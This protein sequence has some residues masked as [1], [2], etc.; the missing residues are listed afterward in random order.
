MANNV[1]TQEVFFDADGRPVLDALKSVEGFFLNIQKIV[2]GIGIKSKEDAQAWGLQLSQNLS[3]LKQ[4]QS[5]MR[6]IQQNRES[7]QNKK[8]FGQLEA[9]EKES[10]RKRLIEYKVLTAD[11]AREAKEEAS[12]EKALA[13]EVAGYEAELLRAQV[14]QQKA[15]DRAAIAS[16][17]EVAA[18]RREAAQAAVTAK[19]RGITNRD[20]ITAA[21]AASDARL[22]QLRREREAMASND[23]AAART[24]ADRIN[25]E[26]VLGRE[27]DATLAKLNRQTVAE[28]KARDAANRR[29]TGVAYKDQAL[30]A[31][32]AVQKT[33]ANLGAV[34]ARDFYKNEQATA[35]SILR[36]RIA[37][38]RSTLES[39]V[40]AQR[41]L[42]I[43]NRRV[44][45]A[46]KL[47][48]EENKV[49][50]AQERQL[51]AAERLTLQEQ[52]T[53]EQA[54]RR[55]L[56]E[57]RNAEFEARRSPMGRIKTAA[58]NLGLY[59]GVAGV[60]Y[61]AFGAIQGGLSEVIQMED[62]LA[63][64]QAIANATEPQLQKMKSAIY[65][66]G[67]ASR[68]SN[69][70]LAKV[71]QTLAQAGVTAGDMQKV[72]SSVTTLATA[73][74]STPDEAV[75][76]V[77]SALGAFQLQ[78]S[79]AARI[80]DLMTSALNRTKLTVQ[81]TGQAIQYVGATAF[82]QNISLEQLLATV[83]AIAQAGVRS[84]STIGTGFRQFLVD[85]QTPSTKLQAQ[86][87]AV[88]L[89]AAQVNVAVRG[90]PAVLKSL[91]EAGFG[92]AQAYGGLETRAAAFYLVAKNNTDI[93]DQLQMSFAQQGAAAIANERAMN[94]LTAQWQRFK[95]ILSSGFADSLEVPMRFLQDLL[96]RLSDRQLELDAAAEKLSRAD[97]G[98]LEGYQQEY[99]TVSGAVGYSLNTAGRD[100]MQQ[101]ADDIKF[102]LNGFGL[103]Q[104]AGVEGIG[105]QWIAYTQK[106][107]G[108]K[109]AT[110]DFATSV[111]MNSE[112][113]EAQSNKISELD[114]EM[115]RLLTQ[116]DSLKDGSTQ[117][118]VETVNLTSRF[119]GLAKFLTN[120]KDK[121]GDLMQAMQRYRQEAL[122]TQ[123]AYLN[124]Q[125]STFGEQASMAQGRATT[126]ANEALSSGRY[127]N[128]PRL[129]QA[130]KQPRLLGNASYI[131]D[132]GETRNDPVLRELSKN[133]GTLAM[134][135]AEQNI[136]RQQRDSVRTQATTGGQS[137]EQRTLASESALTKFTSLS[138]DEQ[139][140]QAPALRAQVQA[141]ASETAAR[142]ANPKTA[143]AAR[144]TL[145]TWE[146]RANAVLKGVDAA[147]AP[148][149]GEIK[150]AAA[151]ERERKAS[152]RTASRNETLVT[153]ADIDKFG[154]DLGLTLG[155]G[156]RTKAEQNSLH[157]RGVTRA[158]GDTSSHSNGGVARDF[159]VRGLDDGAA[160]RMA[161]TLRAQYRAA[162][163]EARVKYERGGPNDGTGRHIHVDVRKGAKRRSDRSEELQDNNE[164]DIAR[165]QSS[166][167]EEDVKIK[168]KDVAQASQDTFDAATKAARA[169]LD[170]L[171]GGLE[172]LALQELATS[173]V[174]P[175][176]PEFSAKLLQVRQSIAQN[177]AEFEQKI[178]DAIIKSTEAQIESAQTAFDQ[179]TSGAAGTLAYSQASAGGL[180]A[181]SLRNRVPDYVKQ[182][183]NDRIGAGQENLAR[184]QY[185]ALPSQI[186]AQQAAIAAAIATS[187]KEG[188]TEQTQAKIAGMNVELEKLI[189]NREALA[190]QLGAGGL[191]PT[192]LGAGLEQ[193][194]QAF[195]QAN[196]LGNTFSQ[197]L[198]M[199]MGGALEQVN[200]GLTSM[201]TSIIEGSSSALG[202]FASFSKGIMAYMV[203]IAAKAVATKLI[204]L[205]LN[206]ASIGVGGTASGGGNAAA[207]G[208]AGSV[209]LGGRSVVPFVSNFKGGP[210]TGY[211]RG[212]EVMNGSRSRDSVNSKLARG[213]FVM[214]NSAVDSV[215][216][217]FMA[218]LNQH[219]A[220]ALDGLQAMPKLDMQTKTETNVWVVPGDRPQ[221]MG[222]NDVKL[223]LTEELMYG[224]TKRLVQHIVREG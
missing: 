177:K 12:V 163:I 186:A 146:V 158:T 53:T 142:L 37:D 217:E 145:R 30:L 215:G 182:L 7:Y 162:G 202:A 143:D 55:A 181:Y 61:A 192:T 52:R 77:T 82:E 185:A 139:R 4:A 89:S 75:N 86:L 140:A 189:A 167:D 14:A 148:T 129:I 170:K 126:L 62:E 35:Q 22:A 133:V 9:A 113:V 78:S 172:S 5:D 223:V 109:D 216:T 43:A 176:T 21:K 83:G 125:I 84:G 107:A 106:I 211:E 90:L 132:A 157:A 171:N 74:G 198:I 147:L 24:I 46:Q 130:L 60:G 149:K 66:I 174:A 110:D 184:V 190:A 194:I 27:L 32:S 152:E 136:A 85:L 105:D 196:V 72:L 222:P 68:F 122:Q 98:G 102:I 178:A 94:S 127:N 193:A 117:V 116:Q 168:L 175:G 19:A 58:T 51:R 151:A 59:G 183:A 220:R 23:V 224:D 95:N 111:A 156:V 69:V 25:L 210:I 134:A 29:L 221:T 3:A 144:A 197:D 54:A 115:G 169:A 64:L 97:K 50:A 47:V 100:A 191:V 73:S 120:A 38:T 13:R 45:E 112:N 79:E 207:S 173:G 36:A 200:G 28:E 70:D 204:G 199:N 160:E 44:I 159:G 87:D 49:A 195:R 165:S 187:D 1:Y 56:Q 11:K 57:Q 42:E 6:A 92:A 101:A 179:Q 188:V 76:L 180:E 103:T 154:Q 161:A 153:Q 81:Q 63:K 123:N 31:P 128:D 67:E 150:A 8:G 88:G 212:G 2:S 119:Q 135:T 20:D 17:K 131:A 201:F 26:K 18:A 16:A 137:L 124:S 218:Q 219:G 164:L 203:Q 209:S 214:Q 41:N 108:A 104:L 114:K 96:K 99:G 33:A 205:L 48:N 65:S 10:N 71:A 93:M 39:R 206:F 155:S 91:N 213:E 138:Q 166:L 141:I 208:S 15:A 34:G 40:E 121:Y 80:A 118:S